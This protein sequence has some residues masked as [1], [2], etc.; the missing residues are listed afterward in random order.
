MGE[1]LKI[2]PPLPGPPLPPPVRETS[3]GL[4]PDECTA[5]VATKRCPDA[6]TGAVWPCAD[7]DAIGVLPADLILRR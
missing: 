5:G 4:G 6:L 7:E 3:C 2:R 1:P